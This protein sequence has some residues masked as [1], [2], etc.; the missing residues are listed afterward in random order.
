MR[1][2]LVLGAIGAAILIYPRIVSLTFFALGTTGDLMVQ[3]PFPFI[4]LAGCIF[5]LVRTLKR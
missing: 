2:L 5:L 3:A 1:I 4:V